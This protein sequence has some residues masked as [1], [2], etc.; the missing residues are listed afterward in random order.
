[1]GWDKSPVDGDGRERKFMCVVMGWDGFMVL[2]WD[3]MGL[4][5][6]QAVVP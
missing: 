1:M 2:G 3:G 6:N 5:Q 4:S